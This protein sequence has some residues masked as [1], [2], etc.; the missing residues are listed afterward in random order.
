MGFFS[1]TVELLCPITLAEI[2]GPQQRVNLSTHEPVEVLRSKVDEN[3]LDA[4]FLH[5]VCPSC[6]CLLKVV[7]RS[8]L[9]FTLC[10]SRDVFSFCSH[11]W[12]L[13]WVI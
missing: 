13:S 11:Y 10:F 4:I 1:G 9:M 12:T 6:C 3:A 2:T 5:G 7:V 8:F